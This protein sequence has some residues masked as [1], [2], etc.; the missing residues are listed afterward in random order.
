MKKISFHW[1]LNDQPN[2]TVLQ[3]SGHFIWCK[4]DL[5]LEPVGQTPLGSTNCSLR[6][7]SSL[8]LLLYSPATENGLYIILLILCSEFNFFKYSIY[9]FG[10]TGS[11]LWHVG[12]LVVACKL[13]VETW[14]LIPW[15]GIKSRPPLHWEHGVLATEPSGKSLYIF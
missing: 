12:S 6:V 4:S 2:E 3:P 13:V 1:S 15:P 10:C 11:L 5:I 9:L 14:D 7:A 8:P